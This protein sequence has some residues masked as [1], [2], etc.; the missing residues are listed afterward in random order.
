MSMATKVYN[1]ILLNR[2]RESIDK[3][4]RPNQAGFRR[5]RSCTDQV[6]IICRIIEAADEKNLPLYITFVDFKKA[7]DS[8]KREKMFEI[9]RHYGIPDKMIRAIKTIYN[10]SKSAVLVEGEL[11]YHNNYS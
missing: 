7:F 9:L 5:G 6:H 10:N 4:L 8:I 3:I 11:T 1:K 2:I